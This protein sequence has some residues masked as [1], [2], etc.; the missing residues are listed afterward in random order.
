MNEC[1]KKLIQTLPNEFDAAIISSDINRRYFTN[2]KSS[3]GTLIVTKSKAIFVIDFR[4][5]EKATAVTDGIEVV[6][7]ENKFYEQLD[8]I[9]QENKV[10]NVAIESDE[11]TLSNYN[12]YCEK[13]PNFNFINSDELSKIILNLRMYKTNEE[14]NFI[15]QAQEI[16][17]KSFS[18]ILNFIKAGKTE[19]EVELEL[20]YTMKKFG[21]SGLAFDSIVVSGKN[22]SLPHG[23]ASNKIIEQG[24]FVTMDFGAKFNGY[25]SDMTR[26]VAIG[27]INDEQQKVYDTVLNAQILA[28]NSIKKD[29]ICSEID[30]IARDYIY[31]QGYENCFGHSLGHSVGLFI[32]E[33]PSFSSNC[34]EKYGNNIIMTVEPGVYLNGKFGV[35]IED[36]VVIV[37]NKLE[38]LT[39]SKKKLIT[40]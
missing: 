2:M 25:C 24:D 10:K 28:I 27:K 36:M 32:H 15:K 19:K 40:L 11:I 30:K 22:T 38:N 34:Y 9:F 26:T 16:T 39:K 14:I 18:H 5:Y 3:A 37:N 7:Q 20:E 8:N 6:L 21:A 4:Y 17:D 1:L 29:C 23:V 12:Y 33:K 13:L 35:R 31:S